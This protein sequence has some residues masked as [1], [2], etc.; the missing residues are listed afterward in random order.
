M[1]KRT[2]KHWVFERISA[3]FHPLPGGLVEEIQALR[4]DNRLLRAKLTLAAIRN[5]RGQVSA[6]GVSRCN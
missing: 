5:G 3:I 6:R 1:S 4:R 2:P